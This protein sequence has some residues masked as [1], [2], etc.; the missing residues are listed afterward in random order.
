MTD[1]YTCTLHKEL[2]VLDNLF[3][4]IYILFYSIDILFYDILFYSIDI[5]FYSIICVIP[6]AMV[7]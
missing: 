7:Q 1:A 3:Y 4:D 5:L 2:D 6:K